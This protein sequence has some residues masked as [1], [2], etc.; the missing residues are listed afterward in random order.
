[1]CA[2]SAGLP[3]R[4]PSP[5]EEIHPPPPPAA[6]QFPKTLLEH[7]KIA[8]ANTVREAREHYGPARAVA[9]AL[10]TAWIIFASFVL[11]PLSNILLAVRIFNFY[12]RDQALTRDY[13]YG[14]VRLPGAPRPCAA[15]PSACLTRY[16]RRG[17]SS[18][19]R[20]SSWISTTPP[21][22]S[23]GAGRPLPV[24]LFVH[25]GSWSAARRAPSSAPRAL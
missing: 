10:R 14:E 22:S 12:Y 16:R 24:V 13:N 8:Y 17:A 25:G 5:L 3:I 4:P 9:A 21:A 2:A 18:R 19:R 23:R 7:T 6:K 1:M 20:T 15:A 11:D